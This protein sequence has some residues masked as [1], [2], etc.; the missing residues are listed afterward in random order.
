MK[1]RVNILAL[2][3]AIVGL[4]AIFLAWFNIWFL[5]TH[6][7]NLLDIIN[8][9]DD[10]SLLAGCWIFLIGVLV[11]FLSPLGGVLEVAGVGI[12]ISW[13][14]GEADKIPSQAGAYVGIVSAVIALVSMVK[15][16]GLGYADTDSG[17]TSRLFVFS[18]R[19]APVPLAVPF[20][21]KYCTFCGNALAPDAVMC[22]KCGKPQ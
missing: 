21:G 5:G 15:P 14:M 16:L 7:Y 17:L 11:C 9:A 20:P 19:P 1:W 22:P 3:G 18:R 4:V 12:F 2:T 13:F 10:Q 8:R 6:N